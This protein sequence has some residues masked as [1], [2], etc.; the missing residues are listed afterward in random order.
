MVQTL[1]DAAAEKPKK[2]APK[3]KKPAKTKKVTKEG[4]GKRTSRKQK[5]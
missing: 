2:K 5:K 3:T 1:K 4:A